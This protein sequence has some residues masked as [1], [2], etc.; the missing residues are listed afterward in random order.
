MVVTTTKCSHF[1]HPEFVLDADQSQVAEADLRNIV[2]AVEDMVAQGSVFEP[3]Q[4]FQIGWMTTQVQ[5][6]DSAR[7]TLFEPDMQG[8]PIKWVPG[9]TR[10]LS[11]MSLQLFILDSVN[12]RDQLDFPSIRQ[13]LIACT[14]YA[15]GSFFMARF[16]P[17]PER[18]ADSGWFVGC[19][20]DDHDHN[21][22]A[23]LACISVYEAYL[24]QRGIQGFVSFPVGAMIVCDQKQGMKVFK[25]GKE[26][27]IQPGSFLDA[28]F[29]KQA[30]T[31]R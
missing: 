16:A 3:G 1:H 20:N 19:T 2:Q 22:S 15:E 31:R 18:K 25:D 10:T 7:L 29:K 21:A 17:V 12:L 9:I 4:T 28:W 5:I 13:S 14:R 27:P 30:G 8:M 24:N 26:L 23:N 6:H 11:R